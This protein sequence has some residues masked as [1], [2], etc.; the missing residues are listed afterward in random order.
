LNTNIFIAKTLWKK[1]PGKKGL[2]NGSSVIAGV[3]VAI[4][5]LVMILAVAISDGFKREIKNKAT[6]FSGEILLHS[7]G[8]DVTTDQYPVNATPSFMDSLISMGNVSTVTPYAYRTGIIKKEDAIQGV[9][10]KG[11]DN[12]FD[13]SFF[14]TSL[15]EGQLPETSDTLKV[16]QLMMSKRL[17]GMLGFSVG[18]RVLVYFID[19]AVKVR[20]FVLSG[21]YDAQL[22][23]LDQSLLVTGLSF[24][25]D[26]NGWDGNE[27]SGLEV[28]LLNHKFLDRSASEIESL[29]ENAPVDESYF[30]TK[31]DELFPHLFDWLRLLDFN[32]LVIMLL[33][34]FVAGFN[35][36]SGLLILLF[37]KT[38]MIGVLK[39]LGM[40]DSAI[41]KIFLSRAMVLVFWGM[42]AGNGIAI[43]LARVQSLYKLIPLD[44]A[45]Y[46]VDHVPIY[47]NW[48]KLLVLN[49]AS[50]VLIAM[51]LMIPSLFI[52]KVSPD[53]TLRVK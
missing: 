43:V 26:V 37:E 25:Q 18:D 17:S 15:S 48:G 38:S 32:V 53:K 35:M 49:I 39:S 7:P 11:V 23:D 8:V 4:S 50:V 16:P 33:M 45:N 5:I 31:V 20:Q 27:V 36:I 9:L 47:M 10:L 3:S 14:E 1:R 41:H 2:S 28:K 29:I 21:I 51:L 22:E 12:S 24:V 42:I 19:E 44:P 30:V 40:R 13:W 46:F 6:G 52:S 34:I